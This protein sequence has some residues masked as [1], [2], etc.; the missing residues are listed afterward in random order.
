M[1]NI[2]WVIL[3][4]FLMYIVLQILRSS[5][6]YKSETSARFVTLAKTGEAWNL[7][8]TNEFRE[9]VKTPEFKSLVKSLAQEEINALAGTVA[10]SV[11]TF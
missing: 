4:A 1:K 7:V 11:K 6:K 10:G 9:L 3:G 5:S 8:R 2:V